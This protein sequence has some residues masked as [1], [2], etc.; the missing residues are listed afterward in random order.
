MCSSKTAIE[1]AKSSRSNHLSNAP[2]TSFTLHSPLA[3]NGP[4]IQTRLMSSRAGQL[5]CGLS[6]SHVGVFPS[7]HTCKTDERF[8]KSL[9]R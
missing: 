1:I 3:E 2:V 8:K 6:E 7:P 9:S 5:H 4:Y